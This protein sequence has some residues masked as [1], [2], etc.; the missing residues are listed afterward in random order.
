MYQRYGVASLP[1]WLFDGF[2][3]AVS[4]G[5]MAKRRLTP[6]VEWNAVEKALG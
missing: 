1:L 3:K 6:I 5:V 2:S 4:S